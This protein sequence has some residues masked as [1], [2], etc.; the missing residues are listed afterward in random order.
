MSVCMH[1][2]DT[3]LQVHVMYSSHYEDKVERRKGNPH[4]VSP[5]YAL[6]ISHPQLI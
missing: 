3:I 6:G 2:P 1:T 4:F 5:K